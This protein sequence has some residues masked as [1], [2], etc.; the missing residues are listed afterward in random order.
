MMLFRHHVLINRLALFRRTRSGF[1][2]RL[3]MWRPRLKPLTI[4]ART[5]LRFGTKTTLIQMIRLANTRSSGCV[6][7]GSFLT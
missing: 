1:L 6:R 4:I 7:L 2:P 5:L 3:I